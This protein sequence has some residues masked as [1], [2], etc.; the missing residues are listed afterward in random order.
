MLRRLVGAWLVMLLIGGG[1]MEW[2]S[3]R[4]KRLIDASFRSFICF[5]RSRRGYGRYVAPVR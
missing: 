5:A 4:F 1:W 2:Q 3:G